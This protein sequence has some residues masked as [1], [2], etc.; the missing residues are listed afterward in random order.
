MRLFPHR[1]PRRFPLP[2]ENINVPLPAGNEVLSAVGVSRLLK[3]TR[4]KHGKAREKP[5]FLA[6]KRSRL[7]PA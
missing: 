1:F 7:E 5:A 6:G 2:A 3:S 4:K